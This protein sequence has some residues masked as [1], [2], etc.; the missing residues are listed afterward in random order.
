MHESVL[1]FRAAYITIFCGYV[2][3][4]QNLI[5]KQQWVRDQTKLKVECQQYHIHHVQKLDQ[6]LPQIVVWL[7]LQVEVGCQQQLKGI[8]TCS[9]EILQLPGRVVQAKNKQTSKEVNKQISKQKIKVVCNVLPGR[10]GWQ[11]VVFSTPIRGTL[12][13]KRSKST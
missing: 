11:V 4:Q 7:T 1:K 5:R 6:E 2:C 8:R 12:P 3:F 10:V 9:D 13:R